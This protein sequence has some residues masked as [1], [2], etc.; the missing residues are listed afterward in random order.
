MTTADN[1]N[2][3]GVI[4]AGGSG[5]RFWP[6]SRSQ[7]PKQVLRL[8]GSESLLQATI[9]RLLPRI[10]LSRLAVV[11]NTAQADVIHMDLYHQGWEDIQLWLEPRGRNTAAAVGLAAMLM[12]AEAEAQIMAVFPA[13]HFIRD[14]ASLLRALDQGAEMAQKGYLVTFG[15]TPTRPDTGYGYIKAGK[16]LDGAGF[17]LHA[18]KFLEKPELARAKAFIQEG[19]YYWNSGIF[20]FRRDVFLSAL[21][22]Y[23][24]ELFSGLAKLGQ[25]NPAV[26]LEEVY[27]EIPSISIDYGVMEKA[28]NVAVLPVDMGW[29]D[30]GTWGAL[31]EL[32]PKDDHGNVV[33]GQK[34]L[35]LH[36]RNSLI[37][38]QNRLV[39]TIGLEDTI[40][41][42]TPD[43]SLVC[44][45]ERVQEV[46]DLVEELTRQSMVESVQHPT[47]ERPWGRYTVMD[48]GP[49]YQV[50]Q[51]VVDPGKRLS[52]QWHHHRAEHWVVVQGTALVTIGTETREVA[53]NE[54]V[55]VPM[56]SPHRLENPGTDPVRIIEVQTGSYLGEDDIVRL[57]DDFWRLS[58][59]NITSHN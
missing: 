57:D 32:F 37:F 1:P 8:L 50:K 49:G 19:G 24:P 51:I 40:V 17:G 45:R 2:L 14:Q 16:P 41:V 23:L 53:T 30:V 58:E 55:F 44:H 42:D 46:K 59:T 21:A 11:S 18:E 36:S 9:A 33:L 31:Y 7:Y 47:V 54:S 22:R 38:S 12:G 27:Q 43:A 29:S 52:Y 5:T 39:A 26:S 3:F 13:D 10:P 35:D 28:A 48:A 15:I 6:L 25:G 34:S 56:K 4:L 20:M